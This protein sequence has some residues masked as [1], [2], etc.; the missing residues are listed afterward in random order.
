[1]HILD[2]AIIGGLFSFT[3]LVALYSRRYSK[4]VADFLAGSRCAGRYLLAIAEGEAAT[5]AITAVAYFQ[6]YYTAGFTA[7]WWQFMTWPNFIIIALSG[8]VIY[9][10]RQTRALT[11]AQFLEVR[12]SRRFR[13]FTGILAFTAGIINFGIFPAVGTKFLIYY[14]A[15]PDTFNVAGF[16]LSTYPLIMFFLISAALWFT[17]MG[18]QITVMLTDFIQ[19]LFCNITYIVIIVVLLFIF[20][21]SKIVETLQTAPENASMLNPLKTSQT[22]NFNVWFFVMM[23]ILDFYKYKSW[24]GNQGYNCAALSPHEARMGNILGTFRAMSQMLIWVMLPIVAYVVMNNPSFA[25]VSA[26]IGDVLDLIKNPQVRSQMT[27]PVALRMVL[28]VGVMGA[29]AAVML[30]AFISNSTT[31]LH[32]W[33][34]IFIQDVIM[35]FRKKPL[36]TEQHLKYLRVSILGVGAFIY[37]FS[38]FFKQTD[39]ILLFLRVTGSIFVSGSG[40]VIIG[41]L[42]WKKGTVWGAWSALITGSLLAVTGIV[43]KQINPE[44]IL[45]GMQIAFAASICAAIIYVLVSLLKPQKDFNLDVMLHRDKVEQEANSQRKVSFIEIALTRLGITR[46]FTNTDKV[47]YIAT[48]I[49][50][51]IWLVVFAVGTVY[52]LMF[53]ISDAAWAS[54]WHF[55]IYLMLS[56]AILFTIWYAF[57][58]IYDAI[59]MFKLLKNVDR[60]ET[61]DGTVEH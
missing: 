43:I 46:E 58:G 2:W 49:W 51:L 31:Y 41:G 18:G 9:R 44:F 22:E 56:M 35:P 42:Y 15:I 50:T 19:G 33:G 23:V 7:I 11:M 36:T 8:W 4:S 29:L 27:T 10:F 53:D 17:Y 61:D 5:A 24:Q 20:P 38:L 57:G 48:I 6:L 39:H 30:A 32:S 13:I 14:C 34:S 40:A 28:P 47:I 16:N 60:E 12:Y 37:M 52:G 21:W 59:Q 45:N 25:A 26:K 55:Y 54:F 1:M 3:V